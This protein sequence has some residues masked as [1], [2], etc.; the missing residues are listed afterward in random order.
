MSLCDGQ[1]VFKT[2]FLGHNFV[3]SVHWTLNQKKNKKI[4]L[5]EKT[6][7]T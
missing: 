3:H 4:K 1:G 7:K 5:F 2:F 6:F